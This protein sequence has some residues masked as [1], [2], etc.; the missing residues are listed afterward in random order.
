[1]DKNEKAL[2][3]KAITL[4]Q[5]DN[6]RNEEALEILYGLVGLVYPGPRS[7]QARQ[8][9]PRPQGEEVDRLID[10]KKCEEV[11]TV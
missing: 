1:M 3:V 6:C 8:E 5:K 10:R 11:L 7:P 9:D 4:L 2:L